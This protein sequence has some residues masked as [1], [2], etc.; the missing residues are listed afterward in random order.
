MIA[1]GSGITPFLQILNMF[2]LEQTSAPTCSVVYG[3]KS[4]NDIWLKSELEKFKSKSIKLEYALEKCDSSWL[5]H[6]G[7]ISSKI[8][9]TTIERP[10]S[11]HL[12]FY[13]G[14]PAMNN[15]VKNIL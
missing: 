15:H 1:G 6:V 5:G 11:S 8:L 12:V 7:Q 2:H 10:C 9:E 4:I 3:N 14:P 13:C